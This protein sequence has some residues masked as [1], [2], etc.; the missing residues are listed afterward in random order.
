MIVVIEVLVAAL[1]GLSCA[2]IGFVLPLMTAL[3]CANANPKTA[4]EVRA[5]DVTTDGMLAT[6]IAT[7]FAL[8]WFF[9]ASTWFLLTALP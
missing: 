5:R 7:F 3:V 6:L 4:D 1:T 2:V 8:A 9:G